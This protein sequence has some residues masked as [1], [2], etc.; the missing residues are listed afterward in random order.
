[1]MPSPERT[2][3]YVRM[4]K[5]LNEDCPS[6]LLSEPISFVLRHSWVRPG[7]SHPFGYGYRR[8]SRIDADA[9]RRAGGR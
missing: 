7:K 8:F 4:L 6:L 3:L 1:M 9:R 5:M 2:A